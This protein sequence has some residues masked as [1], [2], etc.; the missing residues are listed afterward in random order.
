MTLL[1]VESFSAVFAIY[2]MQS[3]SLFALIKDGGKK[4]IKALMQAAHDDVLAGHFGLNKT[5]DVIPKRF[6]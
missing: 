6:F 5:Y 1:T 3:A 2:F 4:T